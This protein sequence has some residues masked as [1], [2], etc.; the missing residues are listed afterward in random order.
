MN[1]HAPT[2]QFTVRP[3]DLR[4]VCHYLRWAI[5]H[6]R[7]GHNLDPKGYEHRG[8]MGDPQFAESGILQAASAM[9]IDL[10][11]KSYGELD[12]SKD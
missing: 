3:D 8:P 5:K 10:G 4:S 1:Y 2:N 7:L 6:I 9:G 12:A 11:A